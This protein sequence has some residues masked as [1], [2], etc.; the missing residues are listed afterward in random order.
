MG[1]GPQQLMHPN[2]RDSDVLVQN[3]PSLNPTA[4]QALLSQFFL[5]FGARAM[6][7]HLLTEFLVCEMYPRAWVFFLPLVTTDI[8]V[9]HHFWN[10]GI[11]LWP[12]VEQCTIC[13]S[14]IWLAL[15]AVVTMSMFGVL[16]IFCLA[17]QRHSCFFP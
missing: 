1:S 2:G 11:P 12:L 14:G 4:N 6:Q 3:G 10:I 8:H 17:V 13:N 16:L 7:R 15:Q 5:S 9:N